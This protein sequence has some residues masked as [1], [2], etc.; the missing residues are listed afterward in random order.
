MPKALHENFAHETPTPPS[1]R[2]TGLVFTAVAI[3]VAVMWRN[4]TVVVIAALSIAAVLAA[5][6]LLAPAILRPLNFAWFWLGIAL[7]RVV[8]PIV[9]LALFAVTIVPFG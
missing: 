7:N 1:E 9:M 8:S 3:L 6:S 5:I 4:S 2:S